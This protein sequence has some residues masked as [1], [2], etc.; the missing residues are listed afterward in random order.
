M[1]SSLTCILN[2]TCGSKPGAETRELLTRLFGEY[3]IKPTILIA[4][5]GTE[6][7]QLAR[8][9]VQD[10]TETIV[11]GGG[12][13]TV[14]AVAT[15]LAGKSST[16]GVLPLGTWNHFAKDLH[17]PMD[18]KEAVRCIATG[19]VANVDVGKV[20]GRIFV[21]N[22]SLGIYPRI[23][24]EREEDQKAGRS[25]WWGFVRAIVS[26]LSRYSLLHV[27]LQVDRNE[28]V[29]DTPFV[30]VGNNQYRTEGFN[31]GER[32]RL[33]EGNLCVY[34]ANRCGRAGLVRLA[35]QALFGQLNQANDLETM[36]VQELSIRNRRRRMSVAT[37]GE[38]NYLPTPI[39][40]RIWAGALRVIVPAPMAKSEEAGA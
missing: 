21:N 30:F 32:L 26:V 7:P 23:V 15:E 16:L 1:S 33:D 25:K 4:A 36:N 8:Q 37:D 28:L 27:H 3:G 40:Y 19:R 6:I 39:E 20:N 18:V 13:G 14:N 12:D 10:K 31:I 17:I 29:R 2:E 11:A 34:V 24:R 38:V 9:A 22:S 5:R 35:L